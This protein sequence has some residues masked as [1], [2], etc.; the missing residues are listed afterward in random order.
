M[1]SGDSARGGAGSRGRRRGGQPLRAPSSPLRAIGV[2]ATLAWL[3]IGGGQP[4]PARAASGSREPDFAAIDAYIEEGMRADRVPGLALAIVRGDRI[5]HLRGFGVAGPDGAPVTPRTSF[6]L[7]S[8][9]KSF[10]ALAVMQLVEAGRLDLDAPVQRYVPWFRVAS[11]DAS[12]R[13]TPRRLLN[14]TS[15]L[16]ERA[17]RAADDDRTLA[18]QVRALSAV[19]LARAPGEAHEYSSPNYQVLGLIVEL[20]SGQPFGEYVRQRIFDPLAMEHSFV[21]QDEAQRAGMASGHQLWFGY[22]VATTLPHEADRL[23]TAALIGSA[24]D[25]A[26]YLIAQLNGGR[27]AGAG[28]VSP[29]GMEELHRPTAAG[30]GF[31]YA[32]G[33][34]V[35]PVNGLPAIHHGGVVPNFRGKMVLLPE[36]RWGV[37][38][39]TN[40]SS[41]L[42]DPTSHRLADGVAGLLAGQAPPRTGSNLGRLY[43]LLGLGF[44]LASANQLK[45]AVTLRRWRARLARRAPGARGLPRRA[46]LSLGVEIALPIVI[47][48]GLPLFLGFPW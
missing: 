39:L 1:V 4:Q 15:G 37:V 12:G 31:A 26:H 29:A 5:V 25:L 8:M 35:G 43:P 36:E 6:V 23:P 7:G 38:V 10:T 3:L 47:L 45:E 14:H 28:V 2:V 30:D 11:P 27:Y 16:P 19:E 34:R 13:I 9:S 22:P 20:V 17:P 42:V 33:W 24:E 48:I 46:L 41:V 44:L 21:S 18:G 32:M 40:V